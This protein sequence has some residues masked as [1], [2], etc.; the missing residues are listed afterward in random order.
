VPDAGEIK[1]EGLTVQQ[2]Q[3][4]LT[5]A[6]KSQFRNPEI[7]FTSI[8]VKSKPVSILGAVKN[9]GVQQAEGDHTLLE[10]ISMAG[11]LRPDAGPVIKVSRDTSV[12]ATFP[13][14][15]R[16]MLQDGYATAKFN[17]AT[18]F[19][20]QRPDENIHI[21]PGDVITVPKGKFVYVV[22]NVQKAGGFPIGE[23]DDLTVLKAVSLAEGLESFADT[24]HARIL[25]AAPDG[26][27]VEEEFDLKKLM[28]GKAEDIRLQA[29]D[30]LFVPNSETKKWTARAIDASISAAVGYAIWR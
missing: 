7:S 11:G 1:A 26:R 17:V 3:A 20:G 9:P 23:T 13:P 16:P 12:A 21:L 2:F 22:G 27:R 28:A 15:V 24:A 30:V 18:L 19:G 8:D 10:M 25:R 5:T 14:E 6:L 4:A 29:N